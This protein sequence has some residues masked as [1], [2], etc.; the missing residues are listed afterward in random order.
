AGHAYGLEVL[1]HLGRD[2][3]V[4]QLRDVF[5]YVD[6]ALGVEKNWRSR[7]HEMIQAERQRHE[8]PAETASA[9]QRRI[10]ELLLELLVD[11]RKAVEADTICL[12]GG[13]FYNTYF[14]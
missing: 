3:A 9:I 11:I 6:G 1:A 10:G 14:N 12:G 7:L 4:E 13:L 2:D 5:R 8:H